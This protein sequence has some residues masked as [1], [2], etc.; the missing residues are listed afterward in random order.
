[1]FGEP[2]NATGTPIRYSAP[3]TPQSVDSQE[4]QSAINAM[5]VSLAAQNVYQSQL[6]NRLAAQ[7]VVIQRRQE[8]ARRNAAVAAQTQAR[9]ARYQSI[10][11]SLRNQV[12]GVLN[13]P[14]GNPQEIAAALRSAYSTQSQARAAAANAA[15]EVISRG[16]HSNPYNPVNFS[17]QIMQGHFN[18]A[19]GVKYVKKQSP[20]FMKILN[21]VEPA[22][23]GAAIISAL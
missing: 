7:N 14:L 6:A 15:N 12:S 5:K 16:G 13:M 22:I 21:Y 3:N 9:Y 2:V 17:G 19:L 11:S 8:Q 20:G 10:I 23:K 18:H 4:Q 1:M